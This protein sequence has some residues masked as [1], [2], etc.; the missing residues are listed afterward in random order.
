MKS[1]VMLLNYSRNLQARCKIRFSLH[2]IILYYTA[3]PGFKDSQNDCRM[4]NMSYKYRT[5]C[6]AQLKFSHKKTQE[7]TVVIYKA[8]QKY[9][10]IIHQHCQLMLFTQPSNG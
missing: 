1:F 2:Y 4:W 6:T 7:N 10:H 9:I 5:V 8:I 3:F